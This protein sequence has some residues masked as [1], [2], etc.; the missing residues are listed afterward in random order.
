MSYTEAMK[1]SNPD[2]VKVTR[3]TVK[4]S[5]T[6]SI[7][8]LEVILVCTLD[9]GTEF[10][11]ET[12][13]KIETKELYDK[14]QKSSSIFQ[15][16]HDRYCEV[17]VKEVNQSEEKTVVQV[18]DDY[19]NEVLDK[20]YK[21]YE[22]YDRYHRSSVR[23]EQAKAEIDA[24]PF[25][26]EQL[27]TYKEEFKNATE[28]ASRITA[29]EDKEMKPTEYVKAA[30][31]QAFDNLVAGSK[32]ARAGYK[33]RRDDESSY[34]AKVSYSKEQRELSELVV[35]LERITLTQKV[36]DEREKSSLAIQAVGDASIHNSTVRD[37]S[38]SRSMIKMNKVECPKFSG[39]PRDFAQFKDEFESIVAV[40]GRQDNEV[41]VQL[42]NAIPKKYVHLINNL[43]L[44]D[45][46]G[47]MEVLVGEFG[48]S[49][50]V[51]DDVVAQIERIKPIINDRTFLDF[52]EKM[53]KIQRDLKALNL[54][55]EIANSAMIGKLE[56]KLPH[57]VYRDWS[58]EVI[59]ADLNKKPS[60]LKFEK[61]MEFLIKTKKQVKYLGAE[62]RQGSSSMA[63]SQTNTCFVTGT[64]FVAESRSNVGDKNVQE[65]SGNLKPCL[66]CSSDGA[67]NLEAS[68]HPMNT[69]DVWKSL[70][71]ERRLVKVKCKKHPFAT[72]HTTSTCKKKIWPCNNCKE[73]NHNSLL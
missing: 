52:T 3:A 62:S 60:K 42:R 22:I 57:L 63:K 16:L 65:R 64:T 68:L 13:N 5:I 54:V 34:E 17:R 31:T 24:I 29:E 7:K 25:R 35:K 2:S 28:V 56:A 11:H 21:L 32:L 30:L 9:S 33:A 50:L 73:D 45:Y 48:A 71:I 15:D 14:L 43:E 58:K 18:E 70:S 10:D 38:T 1:S 12:I 40:P 55:E 46:K 36:N 61:L 41:G 37:S 53:E 8:R 20:I 4:G 66:I 47:M 19:V 72:N 27:N 39:Y 23:F 51:V 6:R 44:A 26:E 67:T 69:C 49:Y 59:D